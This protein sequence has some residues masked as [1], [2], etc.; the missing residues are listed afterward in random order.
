MASPAVNSTSFP[1][2][3]E[4]SLKS[5]PS[6]VLQHPNGGQVREHLNTQDLP[7]SRYGS[8]QKLTTLLTS[9]TFPW[10]QV[11]LVGVAHVSGKV[12]GRNAITAID[13]C[14]CQLPRVMNP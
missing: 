7:C 6:L 11:Y 8:D 4:S 2:S 3:V 5:D 9:E 1:S 10:P 12:R 13:I 14:T